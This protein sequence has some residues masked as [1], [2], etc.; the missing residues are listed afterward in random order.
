MLKR[1]IISL[2]MKIMLIGVIVSSCQ[3]KNNILFDDTQV[4][5]INIDKTLTSYGITIKEVVP[6]ETSNDCLVGHVTQVIS[7]NNRIVVLDA[8]NSNTMF[9]FND[10]GEL[11]FKTIK[12]KGPGEVVD[13]WAI[14][15]NQR[16]S[17][18]YL[19]EQHIR[20]IKEYYFNGNIKNSTK[21]PNLFIKNIFN[22]GN[23]TFLIRH[24]LPEDPEKA[25]TRFINYSICTE[26][27]SKIRHLDITTNS[28]K[29]SH[30]VPNPVS[31]G[32]EQILFVAPY[33]YNIYQLNGDNFKIKYVLDFGD[34]AISHDEME[35]L[36]TFEL[37]P[38]V[39][40]S[41]TNK[42]GCFLGIISHD[43]I[44][45]INME[46][47]DNNLCLFYSLSNKESYSFN[48]LIERG[49]IPKCFIYGIEENGNYYAIVEA[50]DFLKYSK[51][52]GKFNHLN[53]STNDN[54]IF[55]TFELD[56]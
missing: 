6:L 7:W 33:D 8:Y 21:I 49:I 19:Y 44:L 47:G 52:S 50:E 40:E 27:F 2:L 54:P 31:L 45:T 24:S 51:K 18:I 32:N 39:R 20:K 22:I 28:N 56:F 3:Q 5:N 43:D 48:S 16:D 9:V 1:G 41:P 11:I 46:Y 55:I 14:S 4:I 35:R 34:D 42:V 53:I 30:W 17:T 37:M 12:G 15:I 36:S 13:P 25:E 10:R 38:L 26:G 23:D 29:L